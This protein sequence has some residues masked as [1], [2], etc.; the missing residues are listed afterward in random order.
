MR[1]HTR[2]PII[3]EYYKEVLKSGIVIPFQAQKNA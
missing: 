2:V 1:Y 3:K